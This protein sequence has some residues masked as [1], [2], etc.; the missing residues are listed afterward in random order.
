[1]Y[2]VYYFVEVSL[3]WIEFIEEAMEKD[4]SKNLLNP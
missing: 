4:P 1:M 2:T 3:P